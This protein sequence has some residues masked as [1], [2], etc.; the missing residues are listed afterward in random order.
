MLRGFLLTNNFIDP[1]KDTRIKRRSIRMQGYDYSE[2]GYY[3]VTIC[4]NEREDRFG[5]IINGK[6]VHN[7]AGVMVNRWW[8]KLSGKFHTVRLDE[9]IVMPNHFHGIIQIVGADPCVGPM[10]P[11]THITYTGPKHMGGHT[12]PKHM[13]GHTGPPLQVIIQWFKTMVTNEYIRNVKQNGWPM[14][15]K[16]L[17]QRITQKSNAKGWTES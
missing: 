10:N 14:F 7:N 9:N 13:G 12:G 17:F 11:F 15:N 2:P 1:M 8:N 16:R 4:T 6:M 5:E 3:F